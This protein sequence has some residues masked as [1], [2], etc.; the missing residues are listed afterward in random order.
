M[1]Q[2]MFMFDGY[3]LNK[4]KLQ[5]SEEA[6]HLKYVNEDQTRNDTQNFQPYMTKFICNSGTY[7]GSVDYQ[8]NQ[9]F[10]SSDRQILVYD[11]Q[12]EDLPPEKEFNA[13]N[14]LEMRPKAYEIRQ[15]LDPFSSFSGTE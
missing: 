15:A 13:V 8:L 1:N 7:E 3:G 12:Y 5:P 2:W 14:P 10:E 9:E 11:P 4:G 6:L